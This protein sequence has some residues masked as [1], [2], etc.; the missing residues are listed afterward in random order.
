MPVRPTQQTNGMPVR[1]MQQTNGMPV[2]PTQQRMGQPIRPTQTMSPPTQTM[3]QL[4]RPP[5]NVK[6]SPHLIGQSTRPPPRT[7]GQ[8][9]GQLQT[10]GQP[11]RPPQTMRQPLRSSQSMGRPRKFTPQKPMQPKTRAPPPKIPNTKPFM[12]I[13]TRAVSAQVFSSSPPRRQNKDGASRR[14][15]NRS[16]GDDSTLFNPFTDTQM[17]G[18]EAPTFPHTFDDTRPRAQTHCGS[19]LLSEWDD[20]LQ[21]AFD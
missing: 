18:R 17:H 11:M 13:R 9:R 14:K 7:M 6:L 8:Q 19:V 3:G 20:D 10:A 5:K 15:Q 21:N 4:I 12:G 1:P 16:V 2:R